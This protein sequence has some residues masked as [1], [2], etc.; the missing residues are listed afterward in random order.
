MKAIL[1]GL[2]IGLALA[3]LPFLLFD[4]SQEVDFECSGHV[5]EKHVRYVLDLK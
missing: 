3:L 2:L 4:V 5:C 1:L